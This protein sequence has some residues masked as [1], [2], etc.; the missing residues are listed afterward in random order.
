MS[1]GFPGDWVPLPTELEVQWGRGPFPERKHHVRGQRLLGTPAEKNQGP[2]PYRKH[3]SGWGCLVPAR[4]RATCGAGRKPVIC[5]SQAPSVPRGRKSVSPPTHG[6]LLCS[7]TWEMGCSEGKRW[8]GRDRAERGPR[9]GSQAGSQQP[10]SP[11]PPLP[12]AAGCPGQHP[13]PPV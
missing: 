7:R 2:P 8:G 13:Q 11:G 9:L 4:W 10:L 6:H 12:A 3:G 5:S 1:S